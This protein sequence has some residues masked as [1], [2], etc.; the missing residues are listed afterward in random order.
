MTFEFKLPDLGEGIQ[1]AEILVVKVSPGQKVT[2]DEPIFEV[3]T[4]KAVVEIPSPCT[5]VVENVNVKVGDIATVGKVM[6]TFQLDKKGTAVEKADGSDGAKTEMA[7]KESTG[8]ATSK[9]TNLTELK[10]N[11]GGSKTDTSHTIP[12]MP[13]V[14]KL[15]REL[16]VDLQLVKASGSGGRVLSEDVQAFAAARGSSESGQKDIAVI[17]KEGSQAP[18]PL[19]DFSKFGH[20]ERIAVKSIRRK[21]AE[22]MTLSWDHIPHVTHMDEANL[23][24]LE[25]VRVKHENKV[26]T[27]GG[28]L[29]FLAFVLKAAANA[30]AKYPQFNASFDESTNEIILKHYFNLGVA[31]ATEKG[32]IVPV[33]KNVDQKNIFELALELVELT[34]KTKAGKIDIEQLKGG[35]FSITNVGVIGG[36]GM[37]PM[38]NYPEAAI[39]AMGR[40]EQKPIVKEGKIEIGLIMPLALS[41]DHR[42]TDGAEAAYF[43][44]YIVEQLE[45][46]NL[47]A[48]ED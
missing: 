25:K 31:V 32:L 20:I 13:A 34:T 24:A 18:P 5:G 11:E 1:E 42:I 7:R 8:S 47:W 33:I 29:T 21:T 44:R 19:P 40:A 6:V 48:M 23:T 15:A 37:V 45:N 28:K 35:T 36:T 27:K 22:I 46:P 17:K 12:A 39:L 10:S 30:L 16:G 43:V 38:I 9:K 3:E 26:K 2:E 4:D 14:R 41:F